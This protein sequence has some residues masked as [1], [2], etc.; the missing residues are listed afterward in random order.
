MKRIIILAFLSLHIGGLKCLAIT[1]NATVPTGTYEC[2]LT[3]NFKTDN[4][5]NWDNSTFKMAKVDNTHF[6][7]EIPDTVITNAGLTTST[8]RYKY[9]SGPE[10]WVYVEKNSVGNDISVRVYSSSDQVLKWG[11]VC[12]TAMI[13]ILTPKSVSECYITGTF[14][15]WA[16]PGSSNTKMNF[17]TDLSDV[18]GNYFYRLIHTSNLT[19]LSYQF[20]AGPGVAYLQTQSALLYSAT[21]LCS[22]AYYNNITFSR[23]FN[24]A[25]TKSVTIVATVP[26]GTDVVYLMGSNVQWDGIRWLS[27]N[28]NFDGTFTFNINNVDIMQYKYYNVQN[29]NNNEVDANNTDKAD[30]IIDAQISSTKNDVI[31]KWKNPI[32][33]NTKTDIQN[34]FLYNK[35]VN[36]TNIFDNIKLFDICGRLLLSVKVNG[37]YTIQNLNSGLYIF[38]INEKLYK[39][40]IN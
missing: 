37:N 2:W 27:G 33:N 3:G 21:T 14:N 10:D 15:N 11:A 4:N 7:L 13:R 9:L 28:K 26:T 25:S 16:L 12:K 6:T 39:V 35:S 40:I 8:I 17:D 24:A 22:S 30:R 19:T 23:I 5:L 1:F 38:Q 31:V 29:W 20:A 18:N 36:F 32:I 34:V